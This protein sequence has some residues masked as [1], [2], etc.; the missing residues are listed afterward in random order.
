M[1]TVLFSTKSGL[2][3]WLIRRF[4]G[5]RASHSLIGLEISGVPVVLHATVGGVQITH[6]KKWERANHVIREF[7]PKQRPNLEA[8]VEMLNTKY[9]YLALFGFA[10]AIAL[11]RIFRVK[12]R[13]PLASASNVVCSE[14]LLVLDIPDWRGLDPTTTTSETLLANIGDGFEEIRH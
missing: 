3:P 14:F 13:N 4:T 9:D 11:W 5:S 10:W 7:R 12:V 1:T 2:F 8:A 6:R